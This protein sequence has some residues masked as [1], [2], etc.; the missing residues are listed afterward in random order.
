MS[1]KT[2]FGILNVKYT[3]DDL[4]LVPTPLHDLTTA[5]IPITKLSLREVTMKTNEKLS[6]ITNMNIN[7]TCN[8]STGCKNNTCKC[9]KNNQKCTSHCHSKSNSKACCNKL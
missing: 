8:C 7:I 9:L 2:Q 3:A 6:N 4:Q 1:S 5:D